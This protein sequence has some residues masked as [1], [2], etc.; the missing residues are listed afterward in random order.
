MYIPLESIPPT[1]FGADFLFKSFTGVFFCSWSLGL[2]FAIP[3]NYFV[4]ATK[5]YKK[6]KNFL[7]K[8]FE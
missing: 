2:H 1:F 5:G 8:F 3:R 6:Y 4:K 7:K